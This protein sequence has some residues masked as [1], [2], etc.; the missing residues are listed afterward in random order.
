[1]SLVL[2]YPF[3][4]E[5]DDVIP[6]NTGQ[7]QYGAGVTLVDD[8]A[9]GKVAQFDGGLNAYVELP[10]FQHSNTGSV[11]YWIK[12]ILDSSQ[13]VH[14]VGPY[15]RKNGGTWSSLVSKS[16][17][18]K[19]AL[20][21]R[22]LETTISKTWMHICE[23]RDERNLSLYVNGRLKTQ[24][25]LSTFN[26]QAYTLYVGKNEINHQTF[27]GKM[28]DFRIY[29]YALDRFMI[30]EMHSNGANYEEPP[31]I[32]GTVALKSKGSTNL[33]VVVNGDRSV[34]YSVTVADQV[35]KNVS[36]GETVKFHGLE[37]NTTYVCS[38]FRG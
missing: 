29:N 13:F 27:A 28:S 2:R 33:S 6:P 25:S 21:T 26:P 30:S 34:K 31:E 12:P 1:M 11:C 5:T 3:N 17:K 22:T 24:S 23:T 37:P 7:P 8:E 18:I 35:K 16:R 9:M 36:T 38:L 19:V 10:S 15:F 4:G 14:G 20:E 32:P